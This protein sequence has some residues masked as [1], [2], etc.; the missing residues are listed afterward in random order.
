MAEADVELTGSI[1][2]FLFDKLAEAV[3]SLEEILDI[4]LSDPT[5][6]YQ[7]RAIARDAR[8]EIMENERVLGDNPDEA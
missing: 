8:N 6:A 2:E 4:G 3:F 7:M 5:A 1:D